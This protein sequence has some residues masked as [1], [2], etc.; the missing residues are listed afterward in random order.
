M[1]LHRV[2]LFLYAKNA[3]SLVKEL[4]RYF[5]M[6]IKLG[7]LAGIFGTA[8]LVAPIVIFFVV[9]TKIHQKMEEK[10]AEALINGARKALE[11]CNK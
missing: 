1:T 6:L 10:R 3:Y 8:L 7:I 2:F 5:N 9:R 11:Q 4:R